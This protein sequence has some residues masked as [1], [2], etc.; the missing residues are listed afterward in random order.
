MERQ[1]ATIRRI[2]NIKPIEGADTIDIAIIGGWKVIIKKDEF[3]I[4]DLC[5][6]CEIDSI[7][8]PHKDFAFLAKYN[9]IVKT[10]KLRGQISQG[11]CFP[12]NILYKFGY[13]KIEDGEFVIIKDDIVYYIVEGADVTDLIGIK[14]YEKPISVNLSGEI[15]GKFPSE[16]PKTN[17]ERIQNL[18]KEFAE[19]QTKDYEWIVTEKLD[20]TSATFIKL[21]K[22]FYVCSRNFLIMETEN[23]IFWQIAKKYNLENKLKN[24]LKNRNIAIQGEVLG[25]GI[26]NNKYK[27]KEHD[28]YFFNAF[29]IDANQYLAW[30]EFSELIKELELKTV[31][32]I[33]DSV[34][35][36]NL[37]IDDIIKMAEGKSKLDFN[38]ERE[39]IVFKTKYNTKENLG[40]I[41]F[42]V[43]NNKF[44]LKY[45]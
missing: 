36:E 27:L 24:K 35:I 8:P 9:Y 15:R 39:G 14:K 42:K 38:K 26:Q 28:I 40:K 5:V 41:S 33:A 2:D 44:L 13:S 34:R 32:L 10:I 29:D 21:N 20:G 31:P 45:K 43:I 22:D 18:T 19:W 3:K 30:K 11:I 7:L 6:Y 16:V 25:P 23:N 12:L 1:L 17:E 4:G 37:T